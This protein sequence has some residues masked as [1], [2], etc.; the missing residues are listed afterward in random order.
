[1]SEKEKKS[2][3]ESLVVT[4][5]SLMEKYS[6]MPD[7]KSKKIIGE[8]EAQYRNAIKILLGKGYSFTDIIKTLKEDGVKVSSKGLKKIFGSSRS[9]RKYSKSIQ[10]K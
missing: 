5:Q 7:K 6:M 4:V 3:S 10:E 2:S 9:K 8:A 1:M